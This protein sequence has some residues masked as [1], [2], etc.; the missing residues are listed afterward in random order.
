M[1]ANAGVDTSTDAGWAHTYRD[2]RRD[3][4]SDE[5]QGESRGKETDSGKEHG[6]P[7]EK[8]PAAAGSS[9]TPVAIANTI[10]VGL[11]GM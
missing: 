6:E 3:R 10:D 1:D 2:V 5:E 8:N 9:R 4:N 7:R 11:D